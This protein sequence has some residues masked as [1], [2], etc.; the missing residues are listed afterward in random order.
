LV[1]VGLDSFFYIAGEVFI[2][3]SVCAAGFECGDD[4]RDVTA[5]HHRR[6]DH[7]DWMMILFDHDLN[8]L[9]HS[10]EH[11]ADVAS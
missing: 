6:L 5:L 2:D 3:H 9:L 11:S 4:F 10:G 1:A 8:A 7:G